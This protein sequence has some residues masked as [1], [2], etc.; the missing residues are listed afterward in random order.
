MKKYIFVVDLDRCIGCH[1]CQVACKQENGVALGACRNEVKDVGPTG[2]YP[3]VQLYF[4]PAMCQQC[5][6]PTCAEVCPTG[7]CYQDPEDG[8]VRIDRNVCI[9]CQTCAGAC[10][11]KV[12]TFNQELR[13]M[14]K[15]NICAQLREVGEQPAC[16]KNCCGKALHVGD[17]NDPES[18]VSRLIREAGEE[19]VHT[20]RD[21]GNKPGVRYILRNAKW[22]DVL[23]QDCK[24]TKRGRMEW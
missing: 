15:C 13:V 6:N 11:Y 5:E 22:L 23:P 16:V 9:G 10:P 12:N 24:E 14:D 7:A 17:I 1:G 3:D 18:E 21:F 4:L 19:N 20:L 8:V 2:T